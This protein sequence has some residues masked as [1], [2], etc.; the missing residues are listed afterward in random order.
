MTKKQERMRV[1][2]RRLSDTQLE[3]IWRGR[4]KWR[5]RQSTIDSMQ[6]KGLLDSRWR[7]TP[8][9]RDLSRE[10]RRLADEAGET[11]FFRALDLL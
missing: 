1:E 4:V 6:K 11:G 10:F 7:L 8:R 9:G 5:T 3:I 2:L